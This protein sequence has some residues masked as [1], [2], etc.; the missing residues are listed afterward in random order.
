MGFFLSL[1][2]LQLEFNLQER[3]MPLKQRAEQPL[4][5]YVAKHTAGL[6]DVV[7]GVKELDDE[8]EDDMSGIPDAAAI[9]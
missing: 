7:R 1:T 2:L 4:P 3:L 8:E 6:A 5:P 9:K